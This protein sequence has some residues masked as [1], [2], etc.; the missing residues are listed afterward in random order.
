MIGKTTGYTGWSR[1]DAHRRSCK[2]T[3]VFPSVWPE[4][5]GVLPWRLTRNERIMLDV[6]TGN[7]TWAHYIEPLYYDGASFWESP[8]RMWK[9]RRKYRLLLFVLPVVMRDV[10]PQLRESII[11]LASSLRRLD[12]Q[13]NSYER[14]KHLGILPGSR[15]L[16]HAEI[17]SI[18]DDLVRALVLLEGSVPVSYLIPSMHHLVHYGEYAKSHG[19]L[20]MY[21][22]MAFERC[23]HVCHCVHCPIYFYHCIHHLL[24][25][26]TTSTSR[27][28]S[29]TCTGPKLT[30]VLILEW[31]LRVN[32]MDLCLVFQFLGTTITPAF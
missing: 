13:V 6:R 24:Y 12:G 4:N 32:T 30:S 14:A 15:A 21:W 29:K 1:D 7:I 23:V 25:V 22:M 3:D 16:G 17:D 18:N 2:K 27:T 10:V 8:S 28:W 5:G 9:S 31:M 19:I 20:R 11:L 26:D